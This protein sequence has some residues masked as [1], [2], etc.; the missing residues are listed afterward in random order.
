MIK[1][2]LLIFSKIGLLFDI[3]FTVA[4]FYLAYLLRAFVIPLPENAP[5]EFNSL[6]WLLF[7][8]IPVWVILLSYENA[9]I[10]PEKKPRDTYL[11]AIRA[12]FF[13]TLI[14]LAAIFI[15]KAVT[16]SRLF[17]ILFSVIDV[18][19][20]ICLRKWLFPPL[21][22]RESKEVL[23]VGNKEDTSFVK[24]FLSSSPFRFNIKEF[25]EDSRQFDRLVADWIDWVVIAASPMKFSQYED[26][27]LSCRKM[28][29]PVSFAIKENYA[30]ARTR[31]DIE[32]YNGLSLLSFSTAP[33]LSPFLVMKYICDKI[34][35][36]LLLFLLFPVFFITV[37][38]IKRESEGSVIFKQQRCG[39]NGKI[40]NLYKFRTMVKET[41][42]KMDDFFYL[43]EM[44]RVVFKMRDDPRITRIGR[45]LRRLSLDELPQLI[46][47]V[48]GDMSI[49]GPRP[50]IS[51][52][53]ENY[54]PQERRR[55]SM[56]P[57]LTCIWQVSGRNAI[58]FDRWMEL[59][60]EYIDN[61]T[62]LLD[63]KLVLL[64]IP[65]I[66]SGRGA[67]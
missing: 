45:I 3:I 25:L 50:P 63:I 15:L 16:Q 6:A 30:F 39:L 2:R 56:K 58:D 26:I 32:A 53:V 60:L 40:F 47:C 24:E 8:I 21:A 29:I 46:N 35:A 4:A 10:T 18:V 14:L 55:L 12:V 19:F 13:G 44:N 54:A 43:N 36:L 20:L 28:G 7:I 38:L 22:S 17:V 64:T 42:G 52:E 31:F 27:I 5:L 48:K 11:P 34:I 37:L 67:Y 65:A 57:G 9:Y 1:E 49:V 23:I 66:L 61:W 62:P 59:D 51:K 41:E 33:E